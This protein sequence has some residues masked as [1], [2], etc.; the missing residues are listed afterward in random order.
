[1]L[2]EVRPSRADFDVYERQDG[3]EQRE[4]RVIDKRVLGA[5]VVNAER[6]NVC[7]QKR[8][9]TMEIGEEDVK[10][11]CKCHAVATVGVRRAC[12]KG[13]QSTMHVPRSRM[14]Q[15]RTMRSVLRSPSRQ[16][17]AR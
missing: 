11:G 3:I 6:E 17:C 15:T 4:D 7:W 5:R 10:C 1:M 8:S 16:A 9:E 2:R 12:G 14:A 13:K